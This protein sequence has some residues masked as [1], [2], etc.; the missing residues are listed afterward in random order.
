M[1]YVLMMLSEI[2]LQLNYMCNNTLCRRCAECSDPDMPADIKAAPTGEGSILLV[3]RPPLHS[4]G[5]LT[6]YTVLMNDM[7]DREVAVF[8]FSY[9]RF[10]SEK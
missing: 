7:S 6:K 8:K 9:Y 1:R 10:L 4:N 3:W 5:I 2:W